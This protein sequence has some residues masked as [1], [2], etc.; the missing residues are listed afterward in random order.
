MK[1]E[2]NASNILAKLSAL[3]EIA[4]SFVRYCHLKTRYQEEDCH[5]LH[6]GYVAIVFSQALFC[7]DA[8][9]CVPL[10]YHL[11]LLAQS[12]AACTMQEKLFSL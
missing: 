1:D 8:L 10:K 9:L 6:F 4:F 7:D 2:E 12:H 11:K 3:L 5:M